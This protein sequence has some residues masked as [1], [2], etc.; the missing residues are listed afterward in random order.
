[1]SVVAQNLLRIKERVAAAA[2]RSGRKAGDITLVAV[3]KFVDLERMGE[4]L[5]L[6]LS[7]LGENRLQEAAVKIPALA[8]SQADIC[9]HMLGH[10]QSNKAAKAAELFSRVDSLDRA[11]ILQTLE[12]RLEKLGKTMEVLIEVKLSPEVNKSGVQESEL[13]VLMEQ[14]LAAKQLRLRGLMTMGLLAAD[15]NATRA[16]FRRLRELRDQSIAK[17]IAGPTFDTLSMGMSGD[18]EIAIEEGAT[19]IRI[20]QAL[21]GKQSS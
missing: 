9:W 18:Y 17:G 8:L 15:A 16:V 19:E 14:C 10:L 21:F 4:A 5:R 7:H 1:M 11:E 6:G 20:G 13:F 2:L 3:T 12:Q